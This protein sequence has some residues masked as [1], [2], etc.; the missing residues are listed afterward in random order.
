MKRLAVL[1]SILS[2]VGLVSVGLLG[3]SGALSLFLFAVAAVST[4]YLL[5]WGYTLS[6]VID[7][8][9]HCLRQNCMRAYILLHLVPASFLGGQLFLK[10]T[11][12]NSYFYL[13]PVMLF[14]WT[15]RRSWGALYE[16]SG[17]LMYQIFYRGNTGM[18]V[19][20]PLLLAL[21]VAFPEMFGVEIFRRLLVIYYTIHFL[22]TGVAVMHIDKD[23]LVGRLVA[24]A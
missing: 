19:S 5:A 16:I 21:G 12:L 3:G 18:L 20:C 15:G 6:S 10:M 2:I 24:R 8:Q 23:I 22:L 14:F 4:A 1:I 17:S 9:K 7:M 11:P 13:V